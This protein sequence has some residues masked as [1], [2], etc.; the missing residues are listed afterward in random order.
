M[1]HLDPPVI[2]IDNFLSPENC[3]ALIDASAASGVHSIMNVGRWARMLELSCRSIPI[4]AILSTDHRMLAH[5]T[6]NILPLTGCMR[7]SKIGAGNADTSAGA[8]SYDSRRTSSSMLLD[9]TVQSQQPALRQLLSS[10]QQHVRTL[11]DY[12]GV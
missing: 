4:T 8:N 12:K 7:E 5:T 2:T 6:T 11:L 1:L 10:F 3:T 9:P